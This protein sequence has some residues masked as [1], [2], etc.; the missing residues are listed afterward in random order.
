MFAGLV[1]KLSLWYQLDTVKKVEG[2][3]L[4]LRRHAVQNVGIILRNTR[5]VRCNLRSMG[6]IAIDVSTQLMKMILGAASSI[7]LSEC[8]SRILR[9]Q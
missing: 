6:S 1:V 8:Q 2:C 4:C 3:M 7:V 5:L 9:T